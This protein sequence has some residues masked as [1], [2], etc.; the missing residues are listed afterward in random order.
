M[1]KKIKFALVMADDYK[2]RT[3]EE[4]REHFDMGKALGYFLE[5]KLQ[6][7]L[8]DRYYDKEAQALQGIDRNNADFRYRLCEILGAVYE[9][10]TMYEVDIAAIELQNKKYACLQQLTEDKDILSHAAQTAFTQEDLM[11]LLDAGARE[12]YLCGKTFMIPQEIEQCH[13]I[14][15]LGKPE[16]QVAAESRE[17]LAEQGIVLE[18]LLLPEGLREAEPEHEVSERENNKVRK[19]YQVSTL[20]DH[21]M[22]DKDREIAAKMYEAAQDIL[23]EFKF[24]IDAG[25]K[26]LEEA[27]RSINLS[28]AWQRYLDR[29]A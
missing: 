15:I 25:T 20:L 10:E 26:P 21:R 22:S 13:Y 8:S 24:D 14:G 7:W 12:I 1:A 17:R 19:S 6:E 27:A 5:G 18:N 4:L 3:L 11:D 28:G 29:I 23:G 16:V 2:V 9:E